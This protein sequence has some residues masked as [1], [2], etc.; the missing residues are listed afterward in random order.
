MLTN[1]PMSIGT[2]TIE[3]GYFNI[4]KDQLGRTVILRPVWEYYLSIARATGQTC[5][6]ISL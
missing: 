3:I 4:V 1:A 5:L 2:K 6:F